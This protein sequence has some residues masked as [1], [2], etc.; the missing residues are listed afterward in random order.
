M[1]E[2]GQPV[3]NNNDFRPETSQEEIETNNARTT[4]RPI[5]LSPRDFDKDDNQVVID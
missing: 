5:P 4:I 3:R 2:L 1:I